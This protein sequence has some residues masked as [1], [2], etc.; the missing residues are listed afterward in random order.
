METTDKYVPRPGAQLFTQATGLPQNGTILLA[1]GATAS[2]AWWPPAF[3]AALAKAGYRVIA[4]DHRDTGR[5]TLSDPGAPPYDVNDLAGDLVA[6][7]DAYEVPAAHLV[8]MSLG[9]LVSQ[10][11]ALTHPDRVA[12]VTLFA[13]EPLNNAYDGEGMPAEMMAHFG[14]LGTLDWTSREAV[15]AFLLRIAELS[16]APG[17]P[18]DREAALDRI[19]RELD[20]T[21]N[22]QVAF[23][24]A[25][26]A[27]KI[28]PGLM[29]QDIARPTLVIHGEADPLISVAAAR[30]T[31]ELVAGARLIVLDNV[32]HELTPADVQ[33]LSKAILGFIGEATPVRG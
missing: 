21:S 1:M 2:M 9:G 33:P 8:G 26:L 24:H 15:T 20:R 32:G 6:I 4:F 13:A 14:D 17:R 18:F 7:L 19:G 23:N 16:A 27:G 22:M 5:S 12:T 31:A 11:V 30:K 25:M 10:I 28:D 3:I 29:A